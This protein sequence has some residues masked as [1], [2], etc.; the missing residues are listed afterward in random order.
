MGLSAWKVLLILAVVLFL[1]LPR[2]V[3]LGDTVRSLGRRF[4]DERDI[5]ADNFSAATGGGPI[6]DGDTGMVIRPKP[7]P[8]ARTLPERIGLAL[9]RMVRRLFQ[10][11]SA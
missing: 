10:R 8:S 2:F 3:K 4:S 1:F 9:G 7:R 5:D 11:L 6:I